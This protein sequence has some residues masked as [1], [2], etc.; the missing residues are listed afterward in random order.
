MVTRW[1]LSEMTAISGA[2][3][4]RADRAKLSRFTSPRLRASAG[5]AM[6]VAKRAANAASAEAATGRVMGC[7]FGPRVECGLGDGLRAAALISSK[8]SLNTPYHL[9]VPSS[10]VPLVRLEAAVLT[11]D[12][13]SRPHKACGE[14]RRQSG[15]PRVDA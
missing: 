15:Q 1:S 2:P 13:T 7:I 10:L 12:E 14:V 6:P 3:A 4:G 9:C 5:S 11:F 8:R